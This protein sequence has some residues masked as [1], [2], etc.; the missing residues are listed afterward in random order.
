MKLN[1][2]PDNCLQPKTIAEILIKALF[3]V[4]IFAIE[5]SLKF[6][7]KCST[8]ECCQLQRRY[9]FISEVGSL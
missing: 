5:V 7:C 1:R 2:M 4:S 8:D 6:Q 9:A 3:R